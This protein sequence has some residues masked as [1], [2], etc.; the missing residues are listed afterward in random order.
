LSGLDTSG[1]IVETYADGTT[2][3]TT[4]E[5]DASGNPIKITGGDGNVTTLTW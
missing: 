2:K 1:T 4:L 5:F 3:T